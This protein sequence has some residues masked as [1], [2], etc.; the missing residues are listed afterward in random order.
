MK[1]LSHANQGANTYPN[2][3]ATMKD[4]RWRKDGM[5]MVAHGEA[6]C[7]FP[8]VYYVCVCKAQGCQARRN[9]HVINAMKVMKFR[10]EHNHPP[11]NNPRIK[12]DVKKHV[13]AQLSVGAKPAAIRK[14]LVNGASLPIFRKEVPSQTQIYAWQHQI[15]VKDLPTSEFLSFFFFHH[16][17]AFTRSFFLTF[18][19]FFVFCIIL[20]ESEVA[21]VRTWHQVFTAEK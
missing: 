5:K 6:H 21:Y 18:F 11:S 8:K 10:E 19:L 12:P 15:A 20:Q 16:S 1:D 17:S 4:Y 9:I 2:I 3:K 7:K 14:Q 13:I